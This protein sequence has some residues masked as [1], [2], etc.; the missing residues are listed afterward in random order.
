MLQEVDHETPARSNHPINAVY[1]EVTQPDK[2][3]TPMSAADG[4]DDQEEGKKMESESTCTKKESLTRETAMKKNMLHSPTYRTTT[5]LWH[6]ILQTL[7][8]CK[9]QLTYL[10]RV[11]LSIVV[12]TKLIIQTVFTCIAFTHYY[13]LGLSSEAI[14]QFRIRDAISERDV[15]I[16]VS[17]SF[18]LEEMTTSVTRGSTDD[19]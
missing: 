14:W 1:A 12:H 19:M 18:F 3:L 4:G 13:Q 9:S 6:K 5:A 17:L 8:T 11:G 16:F 10:Q 7:V 2:T 15:M